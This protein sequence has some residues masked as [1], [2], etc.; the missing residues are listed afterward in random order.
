MDGVVFTK[1]VMKEYN[2]ILN[3]LDLPR[4]RYNQLCNSFIKHPSILS[5]NHNYK[6]FIPGNNI[7]TFGRAL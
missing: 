5:K 7:D 4:D 2:H 3:N 1:D 6:E